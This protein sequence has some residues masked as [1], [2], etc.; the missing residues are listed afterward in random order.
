MHDLFIERCG[1]CQGSDDILQVSHAWDTSPGRM[2][3]EVLYQGRM[4]RQQTDQLRA[5]TERMAL[6]RA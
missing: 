6:E 3:K 5:V 4:E 1:G 2:K